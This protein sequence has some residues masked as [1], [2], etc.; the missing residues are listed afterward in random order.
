MFLL[1]DNY[2]SFTYNLRHYFGELGAEVVVHR[3]D[4]LSTAEALNLNPQGIIISPG[5]CDPDKAGICL[6]LIEK[7]YRDIPIFGVCLGHQCIGQAFGGTVL[8]A[9]K[10]MHGKVS[11]IHH[12]GVGV[13]K[14]LANPFTAT[15]YHSLMV[16]RES[17]P[18]C[19]EIT[20]NSEDNVIQGLQHREL[21]I[22]GVQFHP[23]SIASEHGHQILKNFIE[24]AGHSGK[25]AA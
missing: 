23:E 11:A 5:P 18:D 1:I 13:F 2:D 9:P 22:F 8:R 19:L 10:P 3:N 25:K 20:A 12:E 17:L 21:P 15:R 14:G 16:E 7:A 6:D 4:A 24:I